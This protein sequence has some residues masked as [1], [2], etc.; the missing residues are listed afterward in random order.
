MTTN[1]GGSVPKAAH[2]KRRDVNQQ[3]GDAGEELVAACMPKPWLVRKVEKDFGLDLH[4]E[5]FDWAEDEPSSADT[6]GEHFFVQVKSQKALKTI[7]RT[8]R[9]RGNVAKYVPDPA[10]GD[11]FDIEVIPCV[12]EV[13]ELMTVEAMGHA[14]PVL[15]CVAGMDTQD[16][17][18]LCLND[19]I[20]KV[21]LP[22][23]PDY[24][25]Q[26]TV[27]VHV[28]KWNVLDPDDEGVGYLWL[29]AKRAKFYSAFNTF[30]YQRHEIGYA[31]PPLV[32]L[33]ADMSDVVAFPP[34]VIAMLEVFISGNLRL[35]IW[36]Q[37]GPAYWSPLKDVAADFRRLEE[38]V[39]SLKRDMTVHESSHWAAVIT[40]VF[41]RASNL[42]R[43]YEELCREWRLPTHLATV[44]DDHPRS[45]HRPEARPRRAEGAGTT[46]P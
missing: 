37:G 5:V 8:V 33:E 44:M 38:V 28:P 39:P 35:D 46:N 13:G 18:Y 15:L 10:E 30:A 45:K 12:L 24:A 4:V 41:D 26:G 31:M 21:L 11:A 29:L 22:N 43:M 6:L 2:R 42:G 17:Y 3:Q 25:S 27:T 14:V 40:R 9:S 19:Y 1:A 7:R 36:E 32:H 16:V 20:S 34:A 23:Q